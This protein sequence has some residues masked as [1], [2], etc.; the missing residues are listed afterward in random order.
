[1]T[2][3]LKV[4]NLRAYY[5]QVQALHGLTFSLEEGSVTTLLGA[6]GAGKT[7]TLRAIC[8]TVRTTGD[9]RVRRQADHQHVDREHRQARHRPGAAG[10]RH[11][12]AHECR[13]EPAARRDH[14]RGQGRH[15]LRHREDVR[16]VSGAEAAPHAAGGPSVRRRAA[17]AG[18]RPRADAAAADAAA[19]RAV[20]RPGPAGGAGRVQGARRDQP[21]RQGDDPRGRAERPARARACRPGLRHRDRRRS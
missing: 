9:D 2:A 4:S 7:T 17:D 6:N 12:H 1:M 14:P 10:T 18:G 11:L 15:H 8:N 21:Q 13:G 19:R 5:G 20:V 16:A 3:S